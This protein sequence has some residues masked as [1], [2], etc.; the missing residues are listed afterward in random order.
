MGSGVM[1]AKEARF[2]VDVLQSLSRRLI[3]D[4]LAPEFF[5]VRDHC[6]VHRVDQGDDRLA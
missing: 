5:H 4:L 3:Q 2:T 6:T 1:P